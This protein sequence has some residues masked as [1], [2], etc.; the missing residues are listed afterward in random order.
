MLNLGSA[1]FLDGDFEGATE[2]WKVSA[3]IEGDAAAYSN[4]GAAEFFSGDFDAADGPDLAVAN[5]GSNTVSVLLNN[6]D[7]SYAAKVDYTTG[8]GPFAVTDQRLY[9]RITAAGTGRE[10]LA[11]SI[12]HHMAGGNHLD[13]RHGNGY[14]LHRLSC[15]RSAGQLDISSALLAWFSTGFA[16]GFHRCLASELLAVAT[17]S[18]TALPLTI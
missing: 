18:Q 2:A 12:S 10:G 14:E 17:K 6:G 1:L 11:G 16:R 9:P 8:T 7:G 13:P 4:L 5:N 3:A 15:W